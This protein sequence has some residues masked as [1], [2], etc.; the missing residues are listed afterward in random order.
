M[1]RKKRKGITP[2]G[3]EALRQAALNNRPWE[4]STGPR[5]WW[6]KQR[7]RENALQHGDRA[8]ATLPDEIRSIIEK[9]R[10][11]EDGKGNVSQGDFAYLLA[12][13]AQTNDN[14]TLFARYCSL[15][16][17]WRKVYYGQILDGGSLSA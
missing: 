15:M 12:M 17:R 6:G 5:T 2:K 9:I 7:S 10:Q 14:F 1:N 4:H 13:S 11:A 3:R 8:W 16:A